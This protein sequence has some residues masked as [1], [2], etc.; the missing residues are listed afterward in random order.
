M[1]IVARGANLS[2][3]PVCGERVRVRGRSL[4]RRWRLW[5]PLTPTLSPRLWR[6]WKGQRGAWRGSPGALVIALAAL[7]A[8][9]VL[10]ASAQSKRP[11]DEAPE[12]YPAH[13]NRDDTFY[14]CTACHS[15]KIIAQQGMSRERWND[16]IDYMV[17]RHKMVDPPG[18]QREQMLDYLS[19]AFP[20]R[21]A[22]GGW[23][24]PFE[25]R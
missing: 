25:A 4:H 2:P 1:T 18:E 20:E 14:F 8:L 23:K 7:L 19:T 5:L 17:E 21:R 12:Q 3:L 9:P 11:T 6:A 24:N 22:P 16:T 10:D 13:P 15:F